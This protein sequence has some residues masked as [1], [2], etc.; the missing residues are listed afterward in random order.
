MNSNNIEIHIPNYK[1]KNLNKENKI[2]YFLQEKRLNSNSVLNRNTL[3]NSNYESINNSENRSNNNNIRK[4]LELPSETIKKNNKCFK[5][6]SKSNQ[7]ISICEETVKKG[8]PLK[9]KQIF[10]INENNKCIYIDNHTMNLF[11]QTIINHLYY[12]KKLN[13]NE[14]LVE[15]F[16]YLNLNNKNSEY[17][18]VG[19]KYSLIYKPNSNTNIN[20][21]N[22]KNNKGNLVLLSVTDYIKCVINKIKNK[23]LDQKDNEKLKLLADWIINIFETLNKLYKLIKFHHCDPK[24][25]QLFIIG[26]LNEENNTLNI[27]TN[28][29]RVVLGDLDKVSFNVK[30]DNTCYRV[31]NYNSGLKSSIIS[32]KGS[33]PEKMRLEKKPR[34]NCNFEKACFLSSIFLLINNFNHTRNIMNYIDQNSNESFILNYI[35]LKKLSEKKYTKSKFSKGLSL[36]PFK[37]R[38]SH[39]SASE[40]VF[41]EE[42]YKN[43]K[44]YNN[45]NNNYNTSVIN[46]ITN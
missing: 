20:V 25:D 14:H 2:I 36:N 43:G 5:P 40:C 1:N 30:I 35:N 46:L 23:N 31:I 39:K 21:N 32:I 16:K 10:S 18:M 42:I 11:V 45:F 27:N 3:P 4:S 8:P 37:D 24:A 44:Y 15:H 26:N 33:V 41:E 22:C 9:F 17:L 28:K 19:N 38:R 12:N 7:Q 34:K 29:P 6:N 13:K